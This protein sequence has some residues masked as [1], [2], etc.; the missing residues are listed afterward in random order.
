VLIQKHIL[1][2]LPLNS[3][4][5]VI[6]ADVDRSNDVSA[7]DLVELR[8][9][10]LTIYDKLPNN[11]SWRFVPKAYNFNNTANPWGFPEKID[12]TGLTKDELNRDFVGVKIG[13]VNG[14]VVPHSLLGSEV[15]GSGST[16]K[17]RTEDRELKQ[18]EE[19]V[20]DFTADNFNQ[21]EGYQFSMTL[22]GLELKAIH[23]GVLK[24]NEGNFGTTRLGQGYVTTSWNDSKGISA[25]GSEVLFSIKVKAIK[26]ILLSES[27]VINSRYT[28]AEAYTS[29]DGSGSLDV[30]LLVGHN[31]EAGY[32]LYQNIPNP[33]RSSTV[34]SYD[35]PQ[36]DKVTLKIT[37][38]TGRVV[39]VYNQE[40]LKGY[41]QLKL[42]RKDL[43][44]AGVLYYTI[45][46]KNFSATKKMVAIE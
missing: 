27:L 22:N 14:T 25:S 29:N 3:A 4:Y 11:T 18:G 24:M 46:T 37:D 31:T 30:T 34:I 16:L 2:V 13:D 23:S 38:V 40:G 42:N 9:L 20:I 15:R 12:I 10:I 26:T 17:F 5:K 7:I 8:K 28:R 41:N 39:R 45:E 43:P 32:A 19:S 36:A 6:A 21:I 44:D 1:G 35:L 33:F